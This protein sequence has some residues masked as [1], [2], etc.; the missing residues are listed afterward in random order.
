MQGVETLK[1]C[2]NIDL[3]QGNKGV[4]TLAWC[5]N[6]DLKQKEQGMETWLGVETLT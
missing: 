4:E 2:E 3:K 5:R 6:L 1:R